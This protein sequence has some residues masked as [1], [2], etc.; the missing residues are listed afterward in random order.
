MFQRIFFGIIGVILGLLLIKYREK[1][2]SIIGPVSFAEKYL[3]TGG[4]FT[5]L[6][7]LGSAAVIL[8]IMYAT[9]T[10]QGFLTKLV[11]PITPQ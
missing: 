1:A 6:L 10:I 4:T 11:A 7:L 3:G 8:S 2:Q 5:F 9:G